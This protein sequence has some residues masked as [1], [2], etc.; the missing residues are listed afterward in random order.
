MTSMMLPAY[1]PPGLRS[2]YWSASCIRAV[3]SP[4]T[5]SRIASMRVCQAPWSYIAAAMPSDAQPSVSRGTALSPVLG[6]GLLSTE[7]RNVRRPFITSSTEPPS[8]QSPSSTQ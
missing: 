5:A 1:W 3:P 8:G 4:P 6:S 2:A 7:P